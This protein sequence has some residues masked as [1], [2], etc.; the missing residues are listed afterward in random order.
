M[1]DWYIDENAGGANNGTSAANAWLSY[2]SAD[3]NG[4]INPG[5]TVYIDKDH[6]ELLASTQS[7]DMG[8]SNELPVR[9]ISVDMADSNSYA[10]G[11]RIGSSSAEFRIVGASA[12]FGV[13]LVSSNNEIIVCYDSQ[14]S[15]TFEDCRL[16]VGS[17]AGDTLTFRQDRA[18]VNFINS[19]LVLADGMIDDTVGDPYGT[20][21]NFYGC[22]IQANGNYEL[23]QNIKMG[24]RMDFI[25]CSLTGFT[26]IVENFGE[27]CAK[28]AIRDC[29]LNSNINL[30]GFAY[31]IG[32]EILLERSTSA[33]DGATPGLVE[34]RN[35]HGTVQESLTDYRTGGA[36]NSEQANEH[37]WLMGSNSVT[38]KFFS[39][40]KTP[41]CTRWIDSGTSNLT[42]HFASTGTLKNDEF[43]I[44]LFSPDEET[45]S[46]TQG[47]YQ[48]NRPADIQTTPTNLTTDA[49]STW[50]GAGV[51]T[52]QEIS[53]TITPDQAGPIRFRGCLGI[54]TYS[55]YFDPKVEVS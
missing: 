3:G 33:T 46:T 30:E 2:N 55:G 9:V 29:S 28:V 16:E 26:T 13:T 31:G 36:N 38:N 53:F 51:T 52:Q 19:T 23:I 15:Q 17:A 35:Y 8:G 1:V 5:D 49:T 42:F 50:N 48:T 39:P 47:E 27:P 22:D 18:V 6:D 12:Y 25:S 45:I 20:I 14:E 37:S 21:V 10:T 32:N 7:F 11:A 34:L 43:W 54:P 24:M 4:S 40:L 41:M 44:E